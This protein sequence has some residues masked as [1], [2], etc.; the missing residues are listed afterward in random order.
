MRTLMLGRVGEFAALNGKS[1]K[2]ITWRSD[3]SSDT[4]LFL[5]PVEVVLHFHPSIHTASHHP[6]FIP[7]QHWIILLNFF[8]ITLYFT[9]RHVIFGTILPPHIEKNNNT[10]S[11]RQ[12]VPLLSSTASMLLASPPIF[13]SANHLHSMHL[14]MDFQIPRPAFVQILLLK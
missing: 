9:P 2:K 3:S 1:K 8:L 5:H 11:K 7:S 12:W 6:P 14:Q 4:I 10:K 13:S